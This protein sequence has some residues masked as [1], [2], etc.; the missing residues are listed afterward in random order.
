MRTTRAVGFETGGGGQGRTPMIAETIEFA[1]DLS[2]LLSRS[3]L[4]VYNKDAG[5]TVQGRIKILVRQRVSITWARQAVEETKTTEIDLPEGV[6]YLFRSAGS[7][8]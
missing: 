2:A 1:E 8:T 7:K 4:R 5:T 6:A 3:D